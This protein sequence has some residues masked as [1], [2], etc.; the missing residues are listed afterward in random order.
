MSWS[1]TQ[2]C[3]RDVDT[4]WS[5]GFTPSF[6]REIGIIS[7]HLVSLPVSFERFGHFVPISR[8]KLGVRPGGQNVSTSLERNWEWDQ[9]ATK[10]GVRPGDQNV[11]ICTLSER[12]ASLER[13]RHFLSIC[14]H[15][16]FRSRDMNTSW[17]P[18]LTPSFVLGYTVIAIIECV[19]ISGT[20]LGVRPGGQEMSTSLKTKLGTRPGDQEVFQ[21]L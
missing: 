10:L 3:S 7:D 20:K 4:S 17:S 13:Y 1:H 11:S 8:T 2:F 14:S 21:S 9:V 16:P 5:P 18:G 12:Q 15:S 6:V 19:H